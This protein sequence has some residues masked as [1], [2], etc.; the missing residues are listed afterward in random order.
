MRWEK[1]RNPMIFE[2]IRT[3]GDRNFAYLLGDEASKQAALVDPSNSPEKCV[4]RA[5]DQGLK[6]VYII[7]THGHY[8]HTDGNDAVRRRTGAKLVA[9][10][11]RADIRVGDGDT[12]SLGN[13]TL[14][15]IHTPGHTED[16]ICILAEGH[17]V[18]GD[19][20]FVGKVGGTDFSTGASK[21]F[22]SLKK[23]LDLPDE[24][25]VWPGH[26]YG[27]APSSTIGNERLTNPFLTRINDL[28]AFVDL[29][30]NWA[31]YKQKHGIK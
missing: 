24:T 18:T 5:E 12:V 9:N 10:G 16:G 28:E 20:L 1:R 26:D 21:E 2:Q 25:T 7:N 27:T 3:G 14:Q 11:G 8:D 22:K 15:I 6:V 4:D 30:Q 13:L 29:K 31:E 23:L 19:T 17:L